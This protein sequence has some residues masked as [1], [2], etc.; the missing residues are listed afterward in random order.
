[1]I[2]EGELRLNSASQ[3]GGADSIGEKF[4]EESF[5]IAKNDT[6]LLSGQFA[7]AEKSVQFAEST[8]PRDP[9]P[10]RPLP[11]ELT[12]SL[13]PLH[14]SKGARSFTSAHD[15]QFLAQDLDDAYNIAFDPV[16][17][18]SPELAPAAPRP[19]RRGITKA[20]TSISPKHEY[21]SGSPRKPERLFSL[22]RTKKPAIMRRQEEADGLSEVDKLLS[23]YSVGSGLNESS[24][25]RELA[26]RMSRPRV[27]LLRKTGK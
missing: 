10:S 4:E 20:F 14:P 1:M 5:L 16:K 9:S 22:K 13:P 27:V 3:L 24:E 12:T 21:E 25:I 6:S 26:S 15:Y 7:G 19:P 17:S 8:N 23:R 11:S 18:P 2:Y